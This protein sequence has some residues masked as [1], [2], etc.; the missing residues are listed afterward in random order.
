VRASLVDI[1]CEPVRIPGAIT[2]QR[3]IASFLSVAHLTD[4][5]SAASVT[6]PSHLDI[7]TLATIHLPRLVTRVVRF[8]CHHVLAR[9]LRASSFGGPQR[10]ASVVGC[11][12]SG[13]HCPGQLAPL[14]TLH[15]G[16]FRHHPRPP[17]QSSGA[18]LNIRR[19]LAIVSPAKSSTVMLSDLTYRLKGYLAPFL[20][21]SL[22][23]CLA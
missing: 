4:L 6:T 18:R 1:D 11:E 20:G 22:Y 13:V 19:P 3:M 14:S 12:W 8:T 17:L 2:G 16:H 10:R 7:T 23:R 15:F 21:S 5:S 9:L